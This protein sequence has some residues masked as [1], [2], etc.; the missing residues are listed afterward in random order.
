[1]TTTTHS[2]AP[3]L[4]FRSRRSLLRDLAIVV[5]CAAIV[6]GFLVQVWSAPKPDQFRAAAEPASIHLRT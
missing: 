4:Q 1:M 6:I 2:A 5:V 3:Q